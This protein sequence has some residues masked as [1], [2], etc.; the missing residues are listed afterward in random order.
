MSFF[1]IFRAGITTSKAS[2]ISSYQL[3]IMQIYI[4]E[5]QKTNK[6]R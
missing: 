5:N 2:I 1:Y 3:F 4:N 6:G